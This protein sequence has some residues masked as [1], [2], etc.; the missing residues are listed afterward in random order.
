MK[1]QNF[2]KKKIEMM[3]IE[4]SFDDENKKV[5]TVRIL[6]FPTKKSS[7]EILFF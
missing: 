1:Y 4:K 6:N 2:K 5:E 3:K 7:R